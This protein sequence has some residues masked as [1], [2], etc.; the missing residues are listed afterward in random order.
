[1]LE[2][3][4]LEKAKTADFVQKFKSFDAKSALIVDSEIDTNLRNSSANIHNVNVLPVCG[5][6]VYDI[7]KHEKLVV[8]LEALKK[9]EERLA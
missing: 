2:N 8:S 4:K 1:V 3:A 7:L 9:I 5:L 6:N